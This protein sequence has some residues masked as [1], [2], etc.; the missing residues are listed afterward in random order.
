M[1][2][3]VTAPLEP[4]HAP[5]PE[6]VLHVGSTMIRSPGA[7][8]S[9]A[10]W[11]V[12]E[13]ETWVGALPPMV[14]VTVSIDC[15]PLPAVITNSPHCAAEPPYCACCCTAQAG[16]FEGTVPVIFVSVQV[17]LVSAC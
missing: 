10:L 11:I 9:I 14:T 6:A 1:V 8:P 2:L 15:L 7:A 16:T 5:G 13:A 4:S 17:T 3:P 12:P